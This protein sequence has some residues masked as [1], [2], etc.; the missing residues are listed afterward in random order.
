M[1]LDLLLFQKHF[2]SSEISFSVFSPGHP[3]LQNAPRPSSGQT[4]ERGSAASQANTPNHPVTCQA[5]TQPKPPSASKPEDGNS[6]TRPRVN[7]AQKQ[8]IKVLE[9]ATN[10]KAPH[11]CKNLEKK[12]DKDTTKNPQTNNFQTQIQTA[13]LNRLTKDQQLKEVERLL[14]AKIHQ[15]TSGESPVS[16]PRS[17]KL[18]I[19]DPR[20]TDC[21]TAE[22][23]ERSQHEIV[24]ASDTLQ[25]ICLAEAVEPRAKH[26]GPIPEG[27][28]E[29]D[30]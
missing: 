19:P 12:S 21:D 25:G 4:S 23:D 7:A 28:E 16:P 8:P 30:V 13:D 2:Y 5:Q 6:Q 10:G 15:M 17:M 18:L 24:P 1:Q 26:L 29:D 3:S 11:S 9:V 27:E 20:D 22:L 14:L